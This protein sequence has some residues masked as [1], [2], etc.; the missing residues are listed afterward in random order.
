M[1]RFIYTA[2]AVVSLAVSGSSLAAAKGLGDLLGLGNGQKVVVCMQP[3]TSNSFELVVKVKDLADYL[4][5]GAIVGTCPA[6][7]P[8]SGQVIG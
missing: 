6:P 5:D 8:A 7:P 1:K 3:Y 2:V 4:L